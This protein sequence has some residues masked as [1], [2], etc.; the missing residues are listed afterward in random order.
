[1][2]HPLAPPSADSA[3]KQMTLM[4]LIAIEKGKSALSVRISLFS[5]TSVFHLNIGIQVDAASL[6]FISFFDMLNPQFIRTTGRTNG[7]TSICKQ[8][9]P[10]IEA[11]GG[12]EQTMEGTDEEGDQACPLIQRKDERS[13]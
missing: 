10:G 5:V 1:M 13:C 2:E 4:R 11:S 3:G 7:A 9:S 8:T 12:S 6:I